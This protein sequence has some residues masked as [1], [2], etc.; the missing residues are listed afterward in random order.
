MKK[1]IVSRLPI[2]VASLG[3]SFSA[4]AWSQVQS[5]PYTWKSVKVVAGGFVPGIEFS[6]KEPGLAYCRTDIGGVYRWDASSKK[7][8]PLND[9]IGES[10][11]FGSETLALDPS[12]ANNVYVGGGMYD[13]EKA[14][15]LCSHDK[16]NTWEIVPVPFTMGGNMDGRGVGERMAVDPNDNTILFYATRHDG[17]W[18]SS[19]AG[20]TWKKVDAFP[21]KG[22]A[23]VISAT[24]YRPPKDAGLSF[25]VF[26]PQSAAAGSPSAIIYVGSADHGGP[27]LFVS[28]DAGKT[29]HAVPG[30][31]K[32][33]MATHAEMDGDE[34]LYIVYDNGF[35]PNGV[36]KGQLWKLNTK[37][38][39]WANVS[40]EKHPTVPGGYG[41][42]S[43]D[44]QHPGT[45]AVA[46]LNHWNPV[47]TV[48]RSTDGGQTWKDISG[49]SVREA[50]LSPYLIW[51]ES[52]PKLGWWMAALAIDPFDSNHAAYGT[53]ATIWGTNDFS[54]VSSDQP[55]HWSPW[56]DGIEETAII[57]LISPSASAHLISAFGDIGG[58]THD[59]LDVSPAKGM[60]SN[61]IFN[62]TYSIDYAGKNPRVIVRSGDSHGEGGAKLGY[63]EDG[64]ESWKPLPAPPP[65]NSARPRG[66]G[67]GDALSISADG[68]TIMH[69]SSAAVRITKDRGQTWTAS[70]GL[71][72]G[73]RSVAD[74]VNAEKFYAVDLKKSQMLVSS[75]GGATFAAIASNGLPQMNVEGFGDNAPRLS[76]TL[77][78][79]GDLWL[80]AG[81]K[82]Y[83]STD[84]GANFQ[85]PADSP[86]A[87]A[88]GFGMAPAGKDYPAIFVAGTLDKLTAIYRS[89]DAGVSWIRIN[90]DQHQYGTR[91]RC[92]SGDPR[93][94]GRVYVG[95]DGRGILYG[96]VAR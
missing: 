77:D 90:D 53:G 59:D 71:P 4:F 44:R 38:G 34:N 57:D 17:L 46:T 54:N 10:N 22:I 47:D 95:T 85:Q 52:Q 39:E 56:A 40:P 13:N 35:G 45:L 6:T 62:N 73:A 33:L 28:G 11:Y 41:G 61:P 55:T 12:D 70:Q 74:R 14:A 51:G 25:V 63:S 8:I 68:S 83:H 80:I 30:E 75:D 91:F 89:D 27:H 87:I 7:W 96:D 50:A 42:L 65:I 88:I 79:E 15:I 29:W 86:L 78:K 20:K 5:Q 81:K 24:G 2:F 66:W 9:A 84:G 67:V 82:L 31:P 32:E 43:L 72:A 93:I 23:R 1:S 60:S 94:F 76:A 69:V 64:G 37:N 92:I 3:M 36:T 18:N 19:D 26:D 58:F 49:K 16:G 21:L 48:W